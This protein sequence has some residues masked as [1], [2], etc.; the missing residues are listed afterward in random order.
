MP[1]SIVNC[2][3]NSH[4][5]LAVI[6]ESDEVD[7]MFEFDIESESEDEDNSSVCIVAAFDENIAAPA[8]RNVINGTNEVIAP[9]I[10]QVV[11]ID[12]PTVSREDQLLIHLSA[13]CTNANV[14]LYH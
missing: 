10:C 3:L 6:P 4:L 14:P 1:N 7:E 12:K 5:E 8:T 11:G 13:L 9:D 2:L